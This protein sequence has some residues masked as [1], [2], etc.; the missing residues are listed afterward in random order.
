MALDDD[1]LTGTYSELSAAYPKVTFR[2]VGVNLGKP[3]YLEQVKTATEDIDIQ[4]SFLNAGYMITGMF[5]SV[6]LELHMENMECNAT[7][8]VQITHLLLQR[9]VRTI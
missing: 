3:G 6:P 7:S 4:C 5:E 8:A 2:K 1:L 9:M